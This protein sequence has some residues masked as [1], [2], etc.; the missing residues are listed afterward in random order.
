M[1][2]SWPLF[3]YFVISIQLT[4]NKCF[5]YKFANDWIR[6]VDLWYWKLPLCQLSHNHCPNDQFC[7]CCLFWRS[8]SKEKINIWN[9]S[10]LLWR[11]KNIFAIKTNSELKCSEWEWNTHR[12]KDMGR[13]S[14]IIE[15]WPTETGTN[16]LRNTDRKTLRF[17]LDW[18]L[19]NRDKDIQAR[20][21]KY[22]LEKQSK[23]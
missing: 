20:R 14:N 7:C 11:I 16:I 19:T 9:A 12:Q 2:H 4:V 8:I 6:T 15:G 23:H 21:Q 22:P 3:L 18:W 5:L 13:D 17:R 10:F 1:G